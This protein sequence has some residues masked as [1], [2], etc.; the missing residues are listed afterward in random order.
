MSVGAYILLLSAKLD[1]TQY[2]LVKGVID[3]AAEDKKDNLYDIVKEKMLT[4]LTNSLGEVVGEKEKVTTDEQAFVADNED[5]FAAWKANKKGWKPFKGK[6]GGKGVFNKYKNDR[7]KEYKGK[8]TNG[9]DSF[10]NVLKCRE[11]G[12]YTHLVKDCPSKQKQ[13]KP[14][15]FYKYKQKNGKQV[16]MVER[17]SSEE[18]T[19]H[20]ESEHEIYYTAIMYTTDKEGLNRFTAEALNCAALDTCCTCTVAGKKW[21]DIFLDTIPDSLKRLVQGP[22][23]SGKTFMFGNEGKLTAKESYKLPVKVAGNVHLISVD[24]IESDI[25]C[26]LSKAE[27]KTLGMTLDMK[28]DKAYINGQPIKVSTTSAG[29]FIMDLIDQDETC[30]FC[31]IVD[32]VLEQAHVVDLMKV[33][34]TQQAKLLGKIHKQFG[35][36]PKK[37]FV[38]L[39]KDAGK[40]MPHFS[41]IIDKIVNKC[42]G[43]I[44]RKRNP[45]RPSVALPRAEDFNEILTM[46]L[47]IWNGK[48]ILYM[49]DMFT[50]YTVGTVIDRKRPNDVVDAVFYHWIKHFGVPGRKMTDNGGEFTGEEMRAVT[51]YL[52]VYKETTAAEAPW[53][54]G[55]CEKN[56]ALVDN[57]LQQVMRDYP[58]LSLNTALAWA[59]SAKNSL[60]NVYGYSSYQ[61]VFGKNPRLPCVINDPPPSWEI[62]PQSKALVK[63]L[64]ALHATREA[65]I[66]AEKSEKLKI[67]LKTKIRTVDRIYNQGEY[68]FYKRENDKEYRGPAKVIVQDGKIV[69]LRH[70]SY[71]IKVSV[72]RLQPVHDDL[73]QE[74]RRQESSEDKV[75]GEEK[76]VPND[77]IVRKAKG[78]ANNKSKKE[79]VLI[80]EEQQSDSEEE[81][82]VQGTFDLND[83]DNEDDHR[84]VD[85]ESDDESDDETDRESEQEPDNELEND[86][87]HESIDDHTYESAEESDNE[88]DNNLNNESEHRL[89][90]NE[91]NNEQC[92][93]IK[94]KK[95]D[96]IEIRDDTATNGRWEIATITG[97][98]GKAKTWPDHWNFRCDSGKEFHADIKEVE[99]R[100]L[101]IEEALAVYTH[102]HLLAIMIPKDRQ[103]TEECIAAKQAELKKLRDFNTYEI[104]ENTG[105]KHITCTWVM[106]QKGDEARARLTARGFQEEEEFPTDSPTIQKY[107][108]RTV[109]A[110]AATKN[111]E[112]TATDIKSAFLQ[113][114]KLDRQV[115]VKPPKEAEQKDKLWR[116]IKCLYGLKDASRAWYNKVADKLEKAG[117]EVS[118]YDPGLFYLKNRDG[119]LVGF[120]GL[121]VDDFISAG[122]PRF[123]T[124]VMPD[125]L[126]IFQVGKS[127][128]R[129]FLYTGFQIDQVKDKITLDQDG[130]VAKLVI[131]A[132]PA[133]R[134]LLKNED[135]NS[136]ELT[137]YRGMVGSTNW[138]V[139]TSRPDLSYDMIH[140]STKFKGGKIDNLKEARKVLTNIVQ[141]KATITLSS[142]GKL[143]KAELWLYT[144][145]SFGNLNDGV[146][147]T[148][149]YI[150]LL[151]NPINGKCAPLDWKAN[152][153]K[154]VVTSTLAAE[155]LSLTCGLDA[156][157]AMREQLQDLLG[158]D[159]IL[160]LRAMVDNKS[161]VDAAHATVTHTTERRL[162]REIG[163]IKGMLKK[164]EL[165]ELKWVPTNLMLADALTKK[166]VNSLKLMQVMQ[167]GQLSAEYLNSVI[168]CRRGY[169]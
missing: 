136:E 39:L 44:L 16:Y 160:T 135:M 166:G 30:N 36:R 53:M 150:L 129:S 88:A 24:I 11:C 146:D 140:L 154:R 19:D 128:T 164:G 105:Q 97:R 137:I 109:L 96:R 110:I 82:P 58:D 163:S 123:S 18:D 143:A 159:H 34:E 70:G 162:K 31:S 42:E 92:E 102:E 131:P 73:Q 48:Y 17:D 161:C 80:K 98:A 33:D 107:T 116:L 72:N 108:L 127:E 7:D 93:V 46:D 64:K 63:N 26:L 2:Q 104:V 165:K 103:N 41:K 57:I 75:E 138:V 153:V 125:I 83:S 144:D 106:T 148:G 117:F 52:F 4:M 45:D 90:D 126:T 59:L 101:P 9:V 12:A 119:K 151:V 62:L 87:E 79:K 169:Q 56:H 15:S 139:R 20:S 6:Q 71:C 78:V 60:S 69:W 155:T 67:A 13:H 25:P 23:K 115:F 114:S 22:F 157:V 120:V 142:V 124:E 61:L 86:S 51:S 152:K 28:N 99:I 38:S 47:K 168:H 10:G 66:K 141:N 167:E 14:K 133:E 145:A 95:N 65:F 112:I 74:Y 3:I 149:A 118:C 122:T 54:N 37:V 8:N 89:H 100:K 121:H 84:L 55:L 5:V 130:Y 43:C 156:A 50:R 134:L 113:G 81:V 94:I 40:W 77:R 35:H 91:E 76:Q 27:M 1:N 147:S 68:A 111:W 85:D 29:H 49:I 21:L 32:E 158:D 132:L